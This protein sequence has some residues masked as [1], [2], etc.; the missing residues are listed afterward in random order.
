[1]E[2]ASAQ[3]D[4]GEKIA[5]ADHVRGIVVVG[6]NVCLLGSASVSTGGRV[7]LVKARFVSLVAQ[8]MANAS[9]EVACAMLV[10]E[11]MSAACSSARWTVVDMA[12]ALKAH[13]SASKASWGQIAVRNHA[14]K[15]AMPMAN[16]RM[17]CAFA[18]LAGGV[19][20][21]RSKCVHQN[22]KDKAVALMVS[23]FA[24]WDGGDWTA[25][26]LSAPT[27]ARGMAFVMTRPS[28]A[29]ARLVGPAMTVAT[30]RVQLTAAA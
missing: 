26:N 30:H 5:L 22:A 6:V 14:Q 19:P 23:V 7:M 11:E 28:N 17:A 24:T 29:H 21:V 2:H 20:C 4:S 10:G 16:A 18:L 13:V 9:M 27:V 8:D 3:R 1:M 15:S 12:N 25:L